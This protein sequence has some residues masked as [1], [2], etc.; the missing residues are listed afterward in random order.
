MSLHPQ[1]PLLF[2]ARALRRT[3]LFAMPACAAEIWSL[4]K[5]L[6]DLDILASSL[7]GTWD[8]VLSQSGVDA[9]RKSLR[10]I[11]ART[12]TSILPPMM[13][14]R[15]YSVWA[16]PERFSQQPP[17]V[18]VWGHLFLVLQPAASSSW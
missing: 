6:V 11:W 12:S 15:Y 16:A 1:K 7:R 3:T 2:S 13:L 10:R 18:M 4:C 8:S 9:R 5:A 14:Q 17:V